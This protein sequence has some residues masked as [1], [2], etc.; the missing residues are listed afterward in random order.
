MS[1]MTM[2][3]VIQFN[4][5]YERANLLASDALVRRNDALL[6]AVRQGFSQAAIAIALGVTPGR[7]S[8]I[9]RRA[10]MHRDQR[11][12]EENTRRVPSIEAA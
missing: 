6:D 5:E 2:E 10:Q 1:T 9:L 8:Q 7:V 11:D 3:T 4:E 12:A